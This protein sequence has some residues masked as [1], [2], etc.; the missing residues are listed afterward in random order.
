MASELKN[1]ITNPD[2]VVD[3]AY[4]GGFNLVDMMKGY[5]KAILIDTI[6]EK[7][8]ENGMVRRHTLS[9]FP[10]THSSNPHDASLPEAFH[11]V[12][13]LGETGLPHEVVIFGIVSNTPPTFDEQVSDEIALVIPIVVQMVLSEVKP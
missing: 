13:T 1:R 8:V 6:Q 4:T 11:L 12:K 7:G 10:R 2:V 9:D 5:D 3:T